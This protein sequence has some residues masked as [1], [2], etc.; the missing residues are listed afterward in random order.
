MKKYCLIG[1][2]LGHSYSAE[3]HA[4]FGYVYDLVE[5]TSQELKAFVE[6]SEYDGFNVTIPY[7]KEIMKYL[8]VIDPQ[9]LE[10]GAVNTVKYKEGKSYG[11]NTDFYGMEYVLQ[12]QSISLADKK[13]VILG[14]GGTSNTAFALAQAKKAQKIVVVSRNGIDNY[15]NI[16]KHYD[17]QVIINTTPV[18]MYPNNG[19]KI[20]DITSFTELESVVDAIYNPLLTPL[21]LDAKKSGKKYASGLAMLV[22]QA[23]FAKDIF[24]EQETDLKEIATIYKKLL[25]KTVNI[26]LIGMPSSGKTTIGKELAKEFNKKFVDI[27]KEI[28]KAFGKSVSAI[29]AEDGEKAFRAVESEM[30][31]KFGKE[32]GQIISTGGGTIT[33]ENAYCVLKQNGIIVYLT[34]D[35]KKADVYG[36]PLLEKDALNVLKKLYNERRSLYIGSADIVA[37]NNGEIATTVQF[38]KE[39]IYENIGD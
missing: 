36:R 14:S 35:L 6:A 25:L 24:L 27:D 17:A 30:L 33:G 8:D 16:S 15:E 10:I 23:K 38:I 37:D 32:K 22:A 2:K 31:I 13:V 12:S 34:R 9:A 28:E 26:V 5:L 4:E 19:N 20:I 29:F 3:I 18:G 7:K 39:Q 21:L 1:G 11:Y